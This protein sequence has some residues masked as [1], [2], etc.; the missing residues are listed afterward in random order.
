VGRFCIEDLPEQIVQNYGLVRIN[1]DGSGW[2][3]LPAQQTAQ[4]PAW[5]P[6]SSE[7]VYRGDRGLQVTDPVGPTRPLVDDIS[8]GS[9]GWSPDGQRLAVQRYLHDHADIF[10]LDAAG[11]VQARLTA[12]ASVL[13]K[14]HN[15]VAPT[16]SPDGRM[17][18]FLSD[19]DGAWRLYRMNAD[20]SDQRPFLPAALREFPLT[21]DFAAE[22]VA[23]W[24][25]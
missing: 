4:S 24:G 18:L 13:E 7:I 2:Q 8:L 17:I 6:I 25:P 3:D 23:S 14:A 21:Y 16:W 12:P 22:R 20:G 10:L 11:N 19:R 9:P 1:A 15:N 5:Q